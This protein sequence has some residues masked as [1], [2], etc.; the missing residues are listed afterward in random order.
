MIEPSFGIGRIMTGILEHSFSVREGSDGKRRVLS[1]PAAIAPVKC[2]LLPLDQRVEAV[3]RMLAVCFVKR[4]R[5][6]T[7]PHMETNAVRVSSRGWGKGRR[8]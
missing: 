5:L 4:G 7:A 1:F 3:V 2:S 6:W 8:A